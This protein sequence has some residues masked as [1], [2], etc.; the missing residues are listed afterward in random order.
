M[1]KFDIVIIGSGVGLSFV[2]NALEKGMTCA[3]IENSK[4]GG[5]CL[6][7]GCIPS[8]ILVYPAD[9]I[10]QTQHAKKIGLDFSPPVISWD[11]IAKR[12]WSKIDKSKDIEN[13]MNDIRNLSVY[14]GT[15]EFTGK[16]TMKVKMNNGEY[17]E[18][19]RGEKFII[20]AGGRSFVP[21]ISG[22]K[23]TGYITS[24]SFFG[25]AFPKAPWKSLVII[26]GGAIGTEFAHIFSAFN[27]KVTVVEMQPHLV[28][29]EEEEISLHLEKQFSENGIDVKLNNK[30]IAVEKTPEG[31]IVT[32]EN[33]ET[34]DKKKIKCQ[35]I[36]IS[37]GIVS[38]TD[39]L[40]IENTAVAVDKR[41]WIVTNEHLETTQKN[42]WALGDINGKYQFRHKANY[43]TNICINNVFNESNHK[44]SA[45]YTKIPWAIFTSPQIAHVGITQKE[46]LKRGNHILV[47]K[48]NYSAV[49]KGFAMGFSQGDADDGFV[50]LI[51]DENM[52]ILGV[53]IIGPHAAIL[54]QS[55]VYLM[56]AGFTCTM[57]NEK[58]ENNRF[59]QERYCIEGGTFKPM[60]NSIVIHPSLSEVTGWVIGNL[61]WVD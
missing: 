31:K 39:I 19:F 10:R 61:V 55:F 33:V 32:I 9:V 12:M 47:G 53:H 1:K 5:T 49:A 26:G 6:T 58:S 38:N 21:P 17:S 11:T 51:A 54:I 48:N 23:E 60:N 43:E 20:A 36:F 24:E 44:T 18:E 34:G 14:K 50:K 2:G 57:Y 42:I 29:T 22:L 41:G 35:E 4:F 15:G 45:D 8:K 30:V 46:A 3:I 52:K 27:T 7:R 25:E 59:D 16:Y 13:S 37:S 28:S 40:Q 56:N